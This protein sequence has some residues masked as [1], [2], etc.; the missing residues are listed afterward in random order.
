MFRTKIN[1]LAT[2]ALGGA[3]VLGGVTMAGP[4]RPATTTLAGAKATP[5]VTAY[6]PAAE[7]TGSRLSIGLRVSGYNKARGKRNGYRLVTRN[8]R[9]MIVKKGKNPVPYEVKGPCGSSWFM[10]TTPNGTHAKSFTFRTGYRVIAPVAVYRWAWRIDGPGRVGWSDTRTG[11][12][13]GAKKEFPGRH[14]I[15][16][17]GRYSGLVTNAW[18]VLTDGRMCASL[19]PTDVRNF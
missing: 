11:F 16:R 19:H 15:V 3:V 8:G 6:S 10:F 13:G 17:H 4:D 18:V 2:A 7:T 1:A 14:A 9:K 12:A 5:L